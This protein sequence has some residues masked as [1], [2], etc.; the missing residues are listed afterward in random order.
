MFDKWHCFTILLEIFLSIKRTII[1]YMYVHRDSTHAIQHCLSDIFV[2]GGRG[3]GNANNMNLNA[4]NVTLWASGSGIRP[5]KFNFLS[6]SPPFKCCM[7]QCMCMV[8]FGKTLR[9]SEDTWELEREREMIWGM[10]RYT[11]ADIWPSIYCIPLAVYG[12]GWLCTNRRKCA[13]ESLNWSYL[14]THES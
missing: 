11:L 12:N 7:V 13:P 6:V 3:Q 5:S 4:R 14:E 1:L 10:Y 8:N 9:L 2:E